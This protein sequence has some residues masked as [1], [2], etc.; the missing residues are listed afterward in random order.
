M[1]FSSFPFLVFAIFQWNKQLLQHHCTYYMMNSYWLNECCT[2]PKERD[3]D[4]IVFIAL[5]I[6]SFFAYYVPH[7]KSWIHD[8]LDLLHKLRLHVLSWENIQ[9]R[10]SKTSLINHLTEKEDCSLC[11]KGIVDVGFHVKHNYWRCR[12]SPSLY[13][14]AH[15][16]TLF[17]IL[18]C[19]GKCVY[20]A[21]RNEFVFHYS[22][23][24]PFFFKRLCKRK[25]GLAIEKWEKHL[26]LSFF[27]F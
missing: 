1:V 14:L 22:S 24:H 17:K 15:T 23:A 4:T 19:S 7:V 21:D 12:L 3:S 13:I 2:G 27:L 6:L 20:S 16:H 10:K 26:F 25:F 5:L 8:F 18:C 9:K 11:I